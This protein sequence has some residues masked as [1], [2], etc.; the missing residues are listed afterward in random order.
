MLWID[1]KG[2]SIFGV[3]VRDPL[4][5]GIIV[6][7]ALVAKGGHCDL[8][9]ATDRNPEVL[10]LQGQMVTLTAQGGLGLVP[11]PVGSCFGNSW[12]ERE[13]KRNKEELGALGQ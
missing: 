10:E 1:S 9:F 11:Q 6:E 2:L 13:V 3:S 5:V 8:F 12:L 7:I 4:R